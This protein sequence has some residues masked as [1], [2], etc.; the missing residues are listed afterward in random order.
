MEEAPNED[1]YQAVI[2][3]AEKAGCQVSRADISI[4]HR[5]PSRNVKPGQGRPIIAKFV[6]RQTKIGLM[7]NKKK[8]KDSENKIYIND[9][10]T[11][12]RA[13]LA[14]AL[15]QRQ[16]VTSVNMIDDKIVVYQQND[17]KTVFDSLFKLYEWDPD[18][19]TLYAKVVYI[20]VRSP[21]AYKLKRKKLKPKHKN[22]LKEQSVENEWIFHLNIRSIDYN[23]EELETHIDTF[24]ENKPCIICLSE[25]WMTESSDKNAY[26]LES[27]AAM[28]FDP[29]STKNEGVAIYVH[30]SLAFELLEL[31]IQKD[32]IPD[33]NYTGVNCTARNKEKFT[34][35]CLYNSPSVNKH[36]FLDQFELLL[37][38]LS[39]IKNYYLIGD[40]NI[41]LLEC[42][43]VADRYLK[44]LENHGCAQGSKNQPV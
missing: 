3:V 20:F 6:R 12:L 23:F 18:L 8:L 7:T 34:V 5:V 33:L 27:Y 32:S 21:L 19:S 25:T 16:D 26:A 2:D 10:L 15:R 11:L 44:L 30:E 14:K 29:G 28:E 22:N 37:E 41:D 43:P 38:S 4:C 40:I 13:R 35:V 39:Q 24:P 9:D 31:N 42:N 17:T 1:V 36:D